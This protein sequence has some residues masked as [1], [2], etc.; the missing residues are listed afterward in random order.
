MLSSYYN[1]LWNPL[2][3]RASLEAEEEEEEIAEPDPDAEI[4]AGDEEEALPE[5]DVEVDEDAPPEDDVGDDVLDDTDASAGDGAGDEVE[6]VAEEPPPPPEDPVKEAEKEAKKAEKEEKKED[7]KDDEAREV[8]AVAA[9]TRG[10]VQ[11]SK[12]AHSGYV[13]QP[14]V[15]MYL[16]DKE[17]LESIFESFRVEGAYVSFRP[18]GMVTALEGMQ[19]MINGVVQRH[20]E[21]VRERHIQEQ[22]EL[23]Y[24]D[25]SLYGISN[26]D[27]DEHLYRGLEGGESG[28]AVLLDP[29]ESFA[30]GTVTGFEARFG[31]VYRSLKEAS[32]A[33]AVRLKEI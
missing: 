9:L 32:E 7:K 29:E 17:S 8:K 3:L 26:S 10:K 33:L 5:E 30:E 2:Y 28:A 27:A 6:P 23:R 19:E 4:E 1:E 15:A 13:D 21:A 11:K 31:V 20:E 14:T 22:A 16:P 12:T 24:H 25:F 18:Y